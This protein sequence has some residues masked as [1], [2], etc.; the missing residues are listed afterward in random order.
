VAMAEARIHPILA[1]HLSQVSTKLGNCCLGRPQAK[2][3]SGLINRV[4]PNTNEISANLFMIQFLAGFVPTPG[5]ETASPMHQALVFIALA[6]LA[7]AESQREDVGLVFC[8][9]LNNRGREVGAVNVSEISL[10]P[11][12][13]PAQL[14]QEIDAF[15]P[16]ISL[17]IKPSNW[18]LVNLLQNNRLILEDSVVAAQIANNLTI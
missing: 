10:R 7:F 5:S 13:A 3:E 2:P 17:A 12:Q 9:G 1:K 8:P 11:D 4:V 6:D 14:Q 15:F 18:I 16:G